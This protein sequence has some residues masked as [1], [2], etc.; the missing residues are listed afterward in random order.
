MDG[1]LYVITGCT[2]VG[3]TDYAIDFAIENNAEIVSCDSLLV[4][5][6]V[7]IGTAKPKPADRKGI[8]HHCM[9]LVEPSEKFDVSMFI[10]AAQ[11]AIDSIVSSGKNVVVVGGSGF[12]LKSFYHP[13]V[14]GIKIPRNVSDLVDSVHAKSGLDGVVPMLISANGGLCPPIDMK[15]PR[16]VMAALKRCLAYGR[17]FGEVQSNFA[18]LVSP[19]KQYQK[20][21]ILLERDREDLKLRIWER[22]KKMLRGGLIDEVKFLLSS[23]DQLG[24]SVKNAIGY[25]ETIN[26]IRGS[27]TEDAL[28]DEISQNTLKLVKKQKTWFK[29]Q[30][31]IDEKII[32]R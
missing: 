8:G 25:R 3:K 19:F 4:Y 27:T 18:S 2:A 9:D 12:Y 14:D 24:D 10:E 22:T 31:P 15:N 29:K 16:R 20:H 32:L 13:V 23:Y 1:K 17:T 21:T 30:I 7:D 26:W 11:R 28:V 5:K 6:H